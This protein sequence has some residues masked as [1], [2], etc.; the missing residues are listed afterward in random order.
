V[1]TTYSVKIGVFSA[2]WKALLDW[3][4]AAAQFVV[5]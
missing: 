4:D 2:G 1:K 5:R 3:N